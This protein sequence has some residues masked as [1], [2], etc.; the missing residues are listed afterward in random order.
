MSQAKGCN[1]QGAQGS[2]QS[3]ETD[4]QQEGEALKA[5]AGAG[6]EGLAYVLGSLPEV[7]E[8]REHDGHVVGAR[9]RDHLCRPLLRPAR[10][11]ACANPP[12]N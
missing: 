4:L 8:L 3:G 2:G 11:C 1:L 10:A 6:D 12:E 9:N 5:E 7:G